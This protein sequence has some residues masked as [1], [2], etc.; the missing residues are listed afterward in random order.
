[1]GRI[2]TNIIQTFARVREVKRTVI[3]VIKSGEDNHSNQKKI[4]EQVGALVG[5]LIMPDKD[6][7]ETVEIHTDG[8]F[9]FMGMLEF[10]RKVIKKPK[11]ND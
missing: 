7:F 4:I 1:M 2:P 9:K 6:D 11:K 8:K 3:D 10:S 5:E